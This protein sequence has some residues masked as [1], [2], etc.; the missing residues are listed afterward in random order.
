M[1]RHVDYLM[2]VLRAMTVDGASLS[3]IDMLS[4]AE[5]AQQAA[6]NATEAA[7]PTDVSIHALIEA[8]V[9]RTPEAIAVRHEDGNLTY[10]EL[11]RRANRLAHRLVAHGVGPDRIVAVCAERGVPM[12]ISLLAILKAGGAYLPLDPSL[13]TERLRQVLDDASPAWMLVD[14]VGETALAELGSTAHR[15][16]LDQ[17]P[18]TDGPTH[19]P[20]IAG[21]SAGQLAYVIY[22]SGSTG[23]PK[24]VMNEHGALVNRLTWMQSAYG[25]DHTDIVI[26]K[27]PFSFDVSVWEFFWPLLAGASLAVPPP[28][29]HKDAPRLAAWMRQWQVTTAHFVPSMLASFVQVDDVAACTSLRRLILSGEALPAAHVLAC[30]QRLPAVAL[31]N[32]Y[33]PTEAAID[34]TAWTCPPDYTGGTVP[35]G[36]PIANTAIHLLDRYGRHVPRG[37]VGELHIGGVGV[38][39][40][41]LNRD[42]LTAERFV[43]DP[44]RAGG[45]LYKTGDLAR[46]APDGQIEYLGRN[47]DQVKIRGFRIELGDIEACLAT[48]ASIRDVAVVARDTPG[49]DVRL[50]AYLV[51]EAGQG[52]VAQWRAHAAAHLPEYMVPAAFVQLAA[53]PLTGNGKLDRKALPAPDDEAFARRAYEPPQGDTESAIAAV[54]EELLGV[55]R[56]GRRD[57]FFE[58]GGHSLLA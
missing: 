32:L 28:E 9:Q 3:S 48:C 16:H 13:P 34:V 7:Y 40:G 26:Q 5:R 38:A 19:D 55:T 20:Q 15:V 37:T 41:Y 56:V 44:F 52:E 39:R 43:S 33:G 45:R 23:R 1:Q 22:T 51:V 46:Y 18:W 50:I 4:A 14:G 30:R 57:H 58:L 12:V 53:L 42:G 21:A 47:D 8:Q 35:I 29:L 24:G 27:T 36:R 17:A 10:T 31:H 6:W 11:N 25:L 2:T 49:S 54:W